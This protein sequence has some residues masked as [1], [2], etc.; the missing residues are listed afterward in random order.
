VEVKVPSYVALKPAL[1]HVPAE[2]APPPARCRDARG[3]K[4][5]CNEDTLAVIDALRAW[6]R[7]M[8]GQLQEIAGLQPK[9]QP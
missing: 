8:V 7:A 9:E 2:P 1:T 4:T 6:G 5:V 3:R